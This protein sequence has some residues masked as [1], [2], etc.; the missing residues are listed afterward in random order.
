MLL[1][2]VEVMVGI[3][4]AVVMVMVLEKSL[5]QATLLEKALRWWVTVVEG[6]LVKAFEKLSQEGYLV[7]IVVVIKLEVKV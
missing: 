3:G 7:E 6:R 5:E 1:A 4:L 2:V